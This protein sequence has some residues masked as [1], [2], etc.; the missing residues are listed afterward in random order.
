MKFKKFLPL[1]SITTL[2]PLICISCGQKGQPDI[3]KLQGKDD[4]EV[5]DIIRGLSLKDLKTFNIQS[6]FMALR[7]HQ[8]NLNLNGKVEEFKLDQ[9]KKDISFLYEDNAHK[10]RWYS[11]GDFLNKIEDF[12]F[13]SLA[14]SLTFTKENN[15]YKVIKNDNLSLENNLDILF[16]ASN[17]YNQSELG[18]AK[19]NQDIFN[20]FFYKTGDF[21]ENNIPDLQYL[22]QRNIS[23]PSFM[24]PL[25]TLSNNI[26]KEGFMSSKYQQDILA[27]RVLEQLSFYNFAK[28][29]KFINK[30]VFNNVQIIPSG[31]KLNIDLLDNQNNSLLSQKQKDHVFYINNFMS[32]NFYKDIKNLKTNEPLYFKDDAVLFSE[33]YN[34]PSLSF[35]RNPLNF[36]DF[37]SLM[38]PSEAYETYNLNA[39]SM[40]VDFMKDDLIILGA[41]PNYQYKIAGFQ[42]SE[43]LNNSY[44]LGYLLVDEYNGDKKINTYKWYSI[45]FTHHKHIFADGFILENKVGKIDT[46]NKD[47]YFSYY[48]HA[49]DFDTNNNLVIS[50]HIN[51]NDFAKDSLDDIINFLMY[52]Q[53][54]NL[55]LWKNHL[56][57]NLPVLKI[58]QD[59]DW[60]EKYLSIIISQYVLKYYINNSGNAD[61]LIKYVKVAIDPDSDYSA[62]LYGLGN[63][64]IQID[65]INHKNESMLTKPIKKII[66]GFNGYDKEP[67]ALK[68]KEIKDEYKSSYPIKGKT[69]PY[70]REFKK[71]Y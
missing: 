20:E 6:L 54:N 38:H 17:K 33:Q 43:L 58:I 36:T 9:N 60:Y 42:N 31:I 18:V 41:S 15:K 4:V 30:V 10:K 68:I 69:L 48:V 59:K 46:S 71:L 49:N 1:V 21:K 22:L 70:I 57:E 24:Y 11:L 63:L 16:M 52:K 8:L 44:A 40:L 14:Y 25:Q 66:S 26:R 19:Y 3:F 55:S 47:D 13:S 61:D 5:K 62:E 39:F 34:Y 67:F 65:F 35:S 32:S 51:P 29:N 64:P 28:D 53:S 45:N 50:K 56:M 27:N 12:E 7:N 23:N 2:S 37:D